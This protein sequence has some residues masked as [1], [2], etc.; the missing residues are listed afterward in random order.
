MMAGPQSSTRSAACLMEAIQ[1]RLRGLLGQSPFVVGSAFASLATFMVLLSRQ[2]TYEVWGSL[3][4]LPVLILVTLPVLAREARREADGRLFALLVIA[5]VVKLG[6]ALLRY[7][8]TKDVYLGVADATGYHHFGVELS[9]RFRAGNF[10]T[11][12]ESLTNTDFIRLLAG[13]VETVIGPTMLGAF[14]VFSW[15][16]FW[17]L[18]LFYRA[19]VIAVPEGRNRSYAHLVL[20]LP[21]L[22]FWPSSIGKESWMV[23]T[24]GIVAFGAAQVLSRKTL[25]GLVFV[26]LGLWLATIVRP[27]I[28]GMVA[29]ALAGAYIFCSRR[30]QRRDVTMIARGLSLAALVILAIILSVR[31]ENYLVESGIDPRGGATSVLQQTSVQTAEGGSTFVPSILESPAL[32]PVA[33]ATVM[34]RPFVFEANN[35]QAVISSLEG[36][37][38]LLLTLSRIRWVLTAVRGI[39]KQPY[40]GFALMYVVVF[41]FAFSGI[42]NFGLLVRQRAQ[43]LP[44]YLILL[45][46]PPPRKNETTDSDVSKEVPS[47]EIA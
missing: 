18:F 42:A 7:H 19:F 16:G 1:E 44:F 11:G 47:P 25:R 24:L 30:S 13:I 34:F 2:T 38:L 26:G 10:S 9:E 23:F 33:I 15:L 21:T 3:V 14:L 35:A 17:G 41:V 20:F 6:G 45:A 22:V 37:F 29:I 39:R 8:F 4:L 40:V 46:I 31:T 12:L 43:L 32:A 36:T 28:A 5:L 27:H